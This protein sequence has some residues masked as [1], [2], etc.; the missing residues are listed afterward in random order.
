M[1]HQTRFLVCDKGESRIL[2]KVK[3]G[4]PH[5]KL[6]ATYYFK[7]GNVTVFNIGINTA[8][9]RTFDSVD[10]IN[11]GLSLYGTACETKVLLHNQC[12]DAGGGGG[13]GTRED[14]YRKLKASG[15]IDDRTL[16]YFVDTCSM[17]VLSLTLS[18]PV[19]SC[20]GSG[21]IE[22]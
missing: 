3:K 13:G 15:R 20:F 8:E 19:K 11:H 14:L 1:R 10:N 17:C 18:V 9:N 12:T 16:V 4:S 21:G 2:N 22:K 7:K 6:L 5:I